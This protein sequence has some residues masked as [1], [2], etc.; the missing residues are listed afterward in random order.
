MIVDQ[1]FFSGLP[2]SSIKNYGPLTYR[3]IS[4]SLICELTFLH[5]INNF[6]SPLQEKISG[7]S[8][9]SL[10]THVHQPKPQEK[11][12]SHPHPPFPIIM[13]VPLNDADHRYHFFINVCFTTELDCN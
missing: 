11:I 7:P 8:F 12:W 6:D 13:I 4:D 3:N 5:G 9:A 10:E 2:L 1:H